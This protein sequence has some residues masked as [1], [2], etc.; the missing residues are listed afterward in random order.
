M[1]ERCNV[2]DILCQIE[3]LRSMRGLQTALGN[4]TFASEF[5]ELVG[6]DGKL[7]EKIASTRGDLRTALAKCGNEDLTDIEIPED[8]GDG[9][10]L[11]VNFGDDD[12]EDDFD[13]ED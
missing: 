9:A 3:A 10:P 2:D 12:E 5:P 7:S 6:M 11:V 4:E 1:E 13:E 8:L